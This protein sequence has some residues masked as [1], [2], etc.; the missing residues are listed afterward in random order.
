M[1]DQFVEVGAFYCVQHHGIANED[2]DV[3]DFKRGDRYLMADKPFPCKLRRLGYVGRP[4]RRRPSHN[5]RRPRDVIE[6][7]TDSKGTSRG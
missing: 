7:V 1:A 3:C 6:G 2:D 5:D 4:P